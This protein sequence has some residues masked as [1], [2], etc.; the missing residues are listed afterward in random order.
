MV[1][2][3]WSPWRL[4]Y[5]TR[6]DRQEGCIFCRDLRPAESAS[7]VVFEGNTCYVILNLYPYN[8]GHLMVVPNRH[9]GSLAE[10]DRDEMNEV[11]LLTQRCEAALSEAYRPQ[12][13]NIGV[14]LGK[15]AGAGVLDHVHVHV[16]PR[17]SGD[18]NFM[19]VTG[20]MRVLPESLGSSAARLRPIFA[21]LDAR[22][23]APKPEA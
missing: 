11:G 23:P 10:L 18:T 2:R 5:I 3:L 9:V 17:W 21:R 16:V 14:N 7:L 20:D 15:A 22:N 13:F 8:N 12:G 6:S 1:D 4:E 19:T